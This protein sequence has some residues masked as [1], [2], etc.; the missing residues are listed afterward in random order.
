MRNEL[1]M[2]PVGSDESAYP[3]VVIVVGHVK[4]SK[5]GK[6]VIR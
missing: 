1:K 6:P 5:G 4:A 3:T 2:R